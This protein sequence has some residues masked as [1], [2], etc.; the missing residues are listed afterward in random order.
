MDVFRKL[1]HSVPLP[2]S[3]R[4]LKPF[5]DTKNLYFKGVGEGGKRGAFAVCQYQIGWNIFKP[6]Q[7]K[8]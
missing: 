4:L 6:T 8:G 1:I 2:F 3:T 5:P 7:F